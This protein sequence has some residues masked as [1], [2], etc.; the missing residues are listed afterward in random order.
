MTKLHVD[1]AFPDY[2][3]SVYQDEKHMMVNRLKKHE[4]LIIQKIENESRF[5]YEFSV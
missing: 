2:D 1:H 4:K 3:H 5:C